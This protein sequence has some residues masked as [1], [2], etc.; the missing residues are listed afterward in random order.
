MRMYLFYIYPCYVTSWLNSF[1]LPW[2]H[3]Y[4]PRWQCQDYRTLIVTKGFRTMRHCFRTWIGHSIQIQTPPIEKTLP[5]FPIT[6]CSW[7][8]INQGLVRSNK[9]LECATILWSASVSAN[10]D[11]CSWL[12]RLKDW[13]TLNGWR[14]SLDTFRA[15]GHTVKTASKC[16][17]NKK[18][19]TNSYMDIN[20]AW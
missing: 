9:I 2:L 14:G 15:H 20:G 13:Q 11:S 1:C 7:C 3:G 19:W 10:S 5:H 8:K 6:T 17:Y 16:Q 4:I 12:K 18:R